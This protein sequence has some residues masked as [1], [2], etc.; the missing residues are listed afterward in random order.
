MLLASCWR[1]LASGLLKE[2]SPFSFWRALRRLGN[3]AAGWLEYFSPLALLLPA[4]CI[5]FAR[6]S[7]R[8]AAFFSQVVCFVHSVAR[9]LSAVQVLAASWR[10]PAAAFFRPSIS[11][12]VACA[13]GG[14]TRAA[15]SA[16]P[17]SGENKRFMKD[18]L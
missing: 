10:R 3:S 9:S 12:R 15:R 8:P 18:L 1:A 7:H 16:A 13:V 6:A 4:A 14:V 5:F 17:I 2:K 11:A